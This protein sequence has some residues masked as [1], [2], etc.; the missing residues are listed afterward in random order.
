MDTLTLQQWQS[1]GSRFEHKG[2][3]IF[4]QDSQLGD[5]TLILI[6]GFP[7]ASWDWHK[8]WQALSKSY[9]V[10]T[11]DLIGY[12]FSDKPKKY[13]YSIFDQAD[14]IVRLLRQLNI[15]EAHIVAHDYGDTVTQEL[16]ARELEAD[17]N[18]QNSFSILSACLLNGG[19][20][21]EAHK[22]KLIQTLLISPIGRWVGRLINQRSFSKNLNAV[23]AEG[24]K[25]TQKE[26]DEYWYMTKLQNGHHISHKLIKY[27]AERVENRQRWVG[28]LQNTKVPLRLINGSADTISGEHMVKRYEELVPNPDV[29]RILDAG[30]YPQLEAPEKVLLAINEFHQR[31][32]NN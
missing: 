32:E 8:Q 28:A 12:G 21:P 13:H 4:F 10:I 1:M 19:L 26:I 16:L 11:L 2:H 23:F 31:L 3:S 7:T 30:H 24:S 20:F 29:I 9:R 5:T 22:P 6:H 15:T 25:P 14:L 17:P 27:M 18:R